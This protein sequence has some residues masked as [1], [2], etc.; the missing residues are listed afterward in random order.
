MLIWALPGT[1]L[2]TQGRMKQDLHWFVNPK[3]E[4]MWKIY[5][6][7]QEMCPVWINHKVFQIVVCYWNCLSLPQLHVKL[8]MPYPGLWLERR[9][10]KWGHGGRLWTFDQPISRRRK[11]WKDAH[12]TLP[13][14]SHPFGTQNKQIKGRERRLDF[15]KMDHSLSLLLL[16]FRFIWKSSWGWPFENTFPTYSSLGIRAAHS[17]LKLRQT[18]SWWDLGRPEGSANIESLAYIY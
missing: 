11:K 9:G 14:E 16:S 1:R 3:K 17:V 10:I 4:L 12:G 15:T 8:E 6:Q 18:F 2:N 13:F 5:H 7:L